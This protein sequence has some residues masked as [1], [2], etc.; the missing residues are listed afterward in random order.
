MIKFLQGDIFNTPAYA[1]VNPVNTLGVMGKGLAL[2]F[3]LRL[4][5]NFEAYKRACYTRSIAPGNPLFVRDRLDGVEKLIIN[6]PT[7][8]HWAAKSQ[9]SYINTGL[10]TLAEQIVTRRIDSIAIPALGCGLGELKWSNVKPVI[11]DKLRGLG[12]VDIYVYEPK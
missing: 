1:L 8:I 6:F 9:M 4:P 5:R 2:E 10:H 7:K 11:E 12:S 3:K